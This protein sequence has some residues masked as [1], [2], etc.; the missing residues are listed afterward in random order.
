MAASRE[1][2]GARERRV[3]R[4]CAKVILELKREGQLDG[5]RRLEAAALETVERMRRGDL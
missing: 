4:R 3:A 1:D 5:A 2:V